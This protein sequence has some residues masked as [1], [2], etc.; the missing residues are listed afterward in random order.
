M[1]NMMDIGSPDSQGSGVQD[2]PLPKKR[3]QQ[4]LQVHPLQAW[5]LHTDP[6]GS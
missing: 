6:W 4:R 1:W 5:S 2:T 3:G